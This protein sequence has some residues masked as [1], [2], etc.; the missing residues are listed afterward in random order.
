MGLNKRS[1]TS[2]SCVKNITHYTFKRINCS[3]LIYPFDRIGCIQFR[4]K[5]LVFLMTMK[6][7]CKYLIIDFIWVVFYYF[8]LVLCWMFNA[9][10]SRPLL[11]A[12][13]LP[14]LCLNNGFTMC[15]VSYLIFFMISLK[16]VMI[17]C[18]FS[19]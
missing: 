4:Q 14:I 10:I 2:L 19:G 13:K 17:S 9:F 7:Y 3:T 11:S 8:V 1:L 5:S 12:Q 16:T 15:F 6:Y 18:S